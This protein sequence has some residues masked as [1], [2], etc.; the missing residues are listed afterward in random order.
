MDGRL[1]RRQQHH[2]FNIFDKNTNN[3]MDYFLANTDDISDCD[4]QS[5]KSNSNNNARNHTQK[6]TLG[7]N[8]GRSS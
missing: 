1:I 5:D 6:L 8:T 2:R 3:T 7:E 4:A